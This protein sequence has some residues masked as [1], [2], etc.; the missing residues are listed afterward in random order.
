MKKNH[1]T[2]LI[3]SRPYT[4]VKHPR[5]QAARSS[6]VSTQLTCEVD[7]CLHSKYIPEYV[8][9]YIHLKRLHYEK[10]NLTNVNDCDCN[11]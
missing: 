3:L 10:T 4:A 9:V 7:R 8:I 11:F 5:K 2:V 6:V 1:V